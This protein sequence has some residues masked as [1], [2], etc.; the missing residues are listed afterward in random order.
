MEN[1]YIKVRD[2]LGSE[3]FKNTETG[4][5]YL[6]DFVKGELIPLN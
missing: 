2:I 5:E 1:K 3:V 4:K 6:M